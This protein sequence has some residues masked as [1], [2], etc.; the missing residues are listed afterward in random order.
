MYPKRH[1]SLLSLVAALVLARQQVLLEITPSNNLKAHA[2]F[3]IYKRI[4]NKISFF[5]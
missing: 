3:M 4:M 5:V 2:E 1:I